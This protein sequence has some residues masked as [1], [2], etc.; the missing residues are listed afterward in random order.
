M[1][2]QVTNSSPEKEKVKLFA[3]MKLPNLVGE[4]K[5]LKDAKKDPKELKSVVDGCMNGLLWN[6]AKTTV[7]EKNKNHKVN[8]FCVKMGE[9]EEGSEPSVEEA[10]E[11][12]ISIVSNCLIR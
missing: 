11:R 1:S 8:Y 4:D 5:A 12:L 3:R 10:K 9:C 7:S 6:H 2:S